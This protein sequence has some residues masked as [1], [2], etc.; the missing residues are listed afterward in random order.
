MLLI[1]Q[2]KHGIGLI[3]LE[4]LFNKKNLGGTTILPWGIIVG[5]PG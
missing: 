4:T 2:N 1:L 5:N 3:Y